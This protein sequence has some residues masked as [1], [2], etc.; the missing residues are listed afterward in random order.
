MRSRTLGFCGAPRPARPTP[1]RRS[2]R[3][4]DGRV[5]RPLPA[6]APRLTARLRRVQQVAEA[7]GVRAQPVAE[8]LRLAVEE[9]LDAVADRL[10]LAGGDRGVRRHPARDD[11]VGLAALAAGGEGVL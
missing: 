6:P 11:V 3:A 8:A 9:A 2:C 1:R 4:A 10:E 5:P 7:L